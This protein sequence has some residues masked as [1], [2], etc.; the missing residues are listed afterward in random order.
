[1]GSTRSCHQS[2]VP[3]CGAARGFP[4]CRPH[5]FHPQLRKPRSASSSH[6][7]NAAFRRAQ[8]PSARGGHRPSRPL[9]LSAEKSNNRRGFQPA[10]R[11]GGLPRQSQGRAL[12]EN[13]GRA[14]P[15]RRIVPSHR[16]NSRLPRQRAG[17][18]PASPTRATRPAQGGRPGRRSRAFRHRRLSRAETPRTSAAG[19]PRLSARTVGRLVEKPC[20]LRSHRQPCHSMENPRSA[21][22]QPSAPPGGRAIRPARRLAA[23]RHRRGDSDDRT[24]EATCRACASPS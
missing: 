12:V 18:A 3:G 6:H 20:A 2:R 21:P 23:G 1:M 11:G 13:R 24:V 19:H 9:R 22:R 7:G 8:P 16:R 17:H 15:R 10:R 4:K 5:R 14:R